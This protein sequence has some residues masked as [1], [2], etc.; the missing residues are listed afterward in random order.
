MPTDVEIIDLADAIATEFAANGALSE[1]VSVR[2][3]YDPTLDLKRIKDSATA[4]ITIVP[5]EEADELDA[6]EVW[7]EDYGIDVAIRKRIVGTTEDAVRSE[8][9]ACMNLLRSVKN[10]Y[11][12]RPREFIRSEVTALWSPAHLTQDRIY[13]G[14]VRLFFTNPIEIEGEDD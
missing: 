3:D 1:P 10:F 7:N 4:F 6:R 11:R 2:R 14:V 9:D 12:L 13:F 8:M 5:A